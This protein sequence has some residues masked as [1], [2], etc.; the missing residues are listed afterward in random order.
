MNKFDFLEIIILYL[1]QKKL[2][3]LI[4]LETIESI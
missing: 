1:L 3:W 2:L 4:F